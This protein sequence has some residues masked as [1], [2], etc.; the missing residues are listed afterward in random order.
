MRLSKQ[1]KTLLP[2]ATLAGLALTTGT[3]LA[4]S[5][6]WTGA[7]VADDATW[8]NDDNWS[9]GVAP[10]GITDRLSTNSSADVVVFNSETASVMPSNN[11]EINN[12]NTPAFRNPQIQVLNGTV[13]FTGGKNWGWSGTSFMVGDGNM[14]TLAVANTSFSE[15]NRDPDGINPRKGVRKRFDA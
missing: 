5:Y 14:A 11:I 13:T 9:G 2:L 7:D 4:A 6:V 12:E 8:Q 10:E 15:L 1:F 3:G